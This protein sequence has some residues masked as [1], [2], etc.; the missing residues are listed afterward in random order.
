[1]N[2]IEVAKKHTGPPV[3]IN[4]IIQELG[5]ALNS[6][7]DLES[8]IS[9]QLEVTRDG[10]YSISTN[11]FDSENRKRFTIA[12]ELGHYMLHSHLIGEGVDDNKAYRSDPTGNFYNRAITRKHETEANRFAAKLLMPQKMVLKRA[13]IGETVADL[14]RVFQVSEAAMKIR[15]ETLGVQISEGLIFQLPE[16]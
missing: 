9:G 11:M 14:A 10:K 13:K 4:A 8:E 2:F 5:I 15:L 3:N 1:M 6:N 7:A 12:H 16:T